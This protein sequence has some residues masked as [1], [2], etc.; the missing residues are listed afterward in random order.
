MK[1]LLPISLLLAAALMSSAVA[2]PG[3][4]SPAA[5][6]GVQTIDVTA[7][8]YEFIPSTI[9]VKQGANVQLKITAT[10]H[11]HGFQISEAPQGSKEKAGLV[12]SSP[13]KC[14][15]IEKG[16]TATLEF[17]AQT[18]G[19]YPFKCCVHCG[20]HHGAMKGQLVV[21]P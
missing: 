15:K 9:R 2:R 16:E 7:K 4:Q 18:A 3:H 1:S 12:F 20:L 14:H 19:T 21:E 10:D 13:Q 17:V 6:Q 8:K 5:T 11:A